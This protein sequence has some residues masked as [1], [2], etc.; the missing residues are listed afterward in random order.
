MKRRQRKIEKKKV[1]EKEVKN[2]QREREREMKKKNPIHILPFFFSSKKT[3]QSL[4]TIL[5]SPY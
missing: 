2:I 5:F 1:I 4:T 3:R